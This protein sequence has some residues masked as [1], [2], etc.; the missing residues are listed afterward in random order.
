MSSKQTFLL[1][2]NKKPN[3]IIY[4]KIN[5]WDSMLVEYVHER[6]F[7]VKK[8]LLSDHLPNPFVVMACL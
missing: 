6:D 5:A 1:G 2:E 7:P 3:F 8:E 4:N